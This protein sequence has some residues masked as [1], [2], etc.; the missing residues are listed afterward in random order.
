MGASTVS[1]VRSWA[2]RAGAVGLAA[3]LAT[4]AL[5]LTG[6]TGVSAAAPVLFSD[7][8]DDGDAVGWRPAG[9]QWSVAENDGHAFQQSAVGAGARARVGEATW[10]DYSVAVE[11]RPLAY[12][13]TRSAVGVQARVQPDGS[14]YYLTTR[15]DATVELGKVLH[16]RTTV[17]ATASYLTAL[18]FWRSLRLVVKGSTLIGVV[19]GT[20]MLTATDTRLRRG[21]IA[22]ATTYAAATFD[23][24]VVESYAASTPDTQAPL[25][26]APPTIV[27]V[28]PTTATISWTPTVDNVGVVDYVVY[29]GS[30]F[31]Q[32][33]PVRVVTGTGPV[34]L[35]LT[36]TAATINFAVAARDAAGNTTMPSG[37]VSIPQPPSFPKTGDDTVPPTAAGNPRLTGTTADGRG[38]LSWTPASD[39]VG[40]VE[41]HVILIVNIDDIRLLAKVTQPTATVSVS[42]S[43][44]LVRVI[45]YDAAWNSSSTPLVPYGPGPTPTPTAPPTP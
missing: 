17:L 39:N 30:G 23:R 18:Q 9:G 11:V 2:R 25:T 24:V 40:I 22:L 45:A 7:D 26:P 8:F 28:T 35:P 29:Q 37:R 36:P 10:A 43:N 15:A 13:D 5:V 21:P 32:Q 4:S 16:G 34:T 27:E 12:R 3:T 38:I 20:T 19:N 1:I 42:G 31:F 44:P 6:P 33:G 14:H 41:Y